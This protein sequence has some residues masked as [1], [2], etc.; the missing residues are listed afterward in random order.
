[1]TAQ[2][3]LDLPG[4]PASGRGE[5][6]VSPSNALALAEINRWRDWPGRKL[7]LTGQPGAGKTHLAHVWSAE[8][9]AR[10]LPAQ[11]LVEASLSAGPTPATQPGNLVVEDVPRIAGDAA[12]EE[13]LFHLHNLVLAEGGYLLL[14]GI[15]PPAQWG[16]RLPDLASRL[17]GTQTA[18]LEAPDDALLAALLVKLFADRGIVAKPTL[19]NWLVRRMERSSAA[20]GRIVAAM[21][22]QAMSTGRPI[23]KSLA[24]DVLEDLEMT[25]T[26][27]TQ[28]DR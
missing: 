22:A 2:L 24:S 26:G 6:F 10:I 7:V 15:A 1:M 11:A 14:T 21:D 17:I 16:I 25:A 23:G 13:A 5:F 27:D 18:S 20:A 8:S 4:Q 19:I 3:T 12:A 9:G 28:D